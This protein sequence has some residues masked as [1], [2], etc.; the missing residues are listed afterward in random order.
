MVDAAE[1][2][3]AAT[4]EEIDRL[5]AAAEQARARAERAR[6]EYSQVQDVADGGDSDRSGLAAELER[7]SEAHD[8]IRNVRWRRARRNAPPTAR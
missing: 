2:R 4:Q 8:R 5:T 3:S 6:L 7:R 1:S